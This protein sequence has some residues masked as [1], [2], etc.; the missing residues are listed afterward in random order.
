MQSPSEIGA[1]G[2]IKAKTGLDTISHTPTKKERR[3]RKR[4][5]ERGGTNRERGRERRTYTQRGGCHMDT[6]RRREG[7][8]H[9][10]TDGAPIWPQ[11]SVNEMY[12]GV[13]CDFTVN[14]VKTLSIY[15]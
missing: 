3:E 7:K 2:C 10:N 1:S 14:V 8:T 9:A 6:Q 13:L 12:V 5:R 11:S 4:E 15:A